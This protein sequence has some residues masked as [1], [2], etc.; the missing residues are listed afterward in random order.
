MS[1]E[2]RNSDRN[3]KFGTVELLHVFKTNHSITF[4]IVINNFPQKNIFFI[5]LETLIFIPKKCFEVC[6]IIACAQIL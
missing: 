5:T 3:L 4:R 6:Q 1:S 2:S